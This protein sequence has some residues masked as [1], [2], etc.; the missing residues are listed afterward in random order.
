MRQMRTLCL[1]AKGT[2]QILWRAFGPKTAVRLT[3]AMHAGL[4]ARAAARK[5][6]RKQCMSN[7]G[8]GAGLCVLTRKDLLGG[9]SEKLITQS[10][11]S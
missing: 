7:G 1:T 8:W 9:H 2:G 3:A 6:A 11:N 10:T 5:A 4:G